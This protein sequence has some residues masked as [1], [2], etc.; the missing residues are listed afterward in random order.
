MIIPEDQGKHAIDS[1]VSRRRFISLGAGAFVVMALPGVPRLGTRHAGVVRRSVPVMG[2]IADLVVVDMDER[3]AH[4]AIDAAIRELQWVDATMSH[5]SATS[6]VGRAN[7]AAAI[8]AVPVSNA[9]A[10]VL[11]ESLHWAEASDGRFD[12][13][14]GHATALWRV[15]Q[16]RRPPPAS[17]V[18]DLPGA[19]TYLNLDLDRYRGRPVVRFRSDRLAIDLGGIA[20]GYGVDRAVAAL[21][22]AGVANALVNAGGD[23]YALGCSDDGNAWTVGVRDPR[24]P[25]RLAAT[26]EMSDRGVATSGDYFQFFDHDGRRYHHLLDPVTGEPR[27]SRQHSVTVAAATCM[28]ADAAATSVFGLDLEAEQAMLERSGSGAEIVHSA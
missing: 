2:T 14:L 26:L 13:C 9:T 1:R 16:R 8:E 4:A 3:R 22:D 15:D 28:T 23:L 10:E 25:A 5:F 19:G 11:A 7:T 21:R 24:D 20:K 18:A 12:P 27:Q 17:E 6:D